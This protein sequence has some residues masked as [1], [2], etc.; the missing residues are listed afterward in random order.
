MMKIKGGGETMKDR[1]NWSEAK[2][3]Y[4]SAINELVEDSND[5]NLLDL[6]YQ[7]LVKSEKVEKG[8]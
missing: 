5:I 3:F 4:V 6:I 2:K 1:N 7:I 8:A